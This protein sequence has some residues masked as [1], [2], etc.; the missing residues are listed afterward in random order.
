[1]VRTASPDR[2]RATSRRLVR[3][4][5]LRDAARSGYAARAMIVLPTFQAAD[6]TGFAAY[7]YGFF[8]HGRTTAG[9]ARS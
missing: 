6:V 3:A 9:R 2:V 8:F 1:M 5:G 4:S 7:A